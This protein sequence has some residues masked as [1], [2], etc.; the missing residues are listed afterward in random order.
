MGKGIS[1]GM[2]LLLG[3]SG[4]AAIYGPNWEPRTVE[5]DAEETAEADEVDSDSET[6]GFDEVDPFGTDPDVS[7]PAEGGGG[8]DDAE[9]AA[10]EGGDEGLARPASPAKQGCADLEERTCKVT[11]GCAWDSVKNCVDE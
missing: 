8:E 1:L 3:A 11:V 9:V 5:S 6:S 4:C 7:E 10:D 2:V